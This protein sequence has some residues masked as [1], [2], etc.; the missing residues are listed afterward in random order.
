MKDEFSAWCGR[1]N[2][3][4]QQDKIDAS[5]FKEVEGLDEVFERTPQRSS[6]QTI[7]VSPDR[8][9]ARSCSNPLRSKFEPVMTS[10]KYFSQPASFN[11]SLCN[12]SFCSCLETRM[13]PIF[14]QPLLFVSVTHLI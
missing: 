9:N 1:I 13:Y 11:A 4:S 10:L 3:F 5:L 7:T 14:I 8:A 2:V 12:A 6:F